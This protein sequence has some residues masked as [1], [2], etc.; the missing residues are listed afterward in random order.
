[1]TLGSGTI[2]V[3]D[4]IEIKKRELHGAF[5]YDIW[6]PAIVKNV[7]TTG[8]GVEIIKTKELLIVSKHECGN[9]W[10]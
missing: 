9:Q 7:W 6:Y 3:G 8:Y 10:R 1:M 2:D 5:V 4:M